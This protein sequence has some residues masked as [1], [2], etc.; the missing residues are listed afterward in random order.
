MGNGKILTFCVISSCTDVMVGS[1]RR[2][3]YGCH[4]GL[5]TR[6]CMHSG[7]RRLMILEMFC[8]TY[9]MFLYELLILGIGL[10]IEETII[11]IEYLIVHF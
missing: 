8:T 10:H 3:G 1:T 4:G 11:D 9:I 6:G 7:L 2:L 5:N